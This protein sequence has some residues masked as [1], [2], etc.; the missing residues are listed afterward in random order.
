[1][2]ASPRAH[3]ADENAPTDL[4]R[5]IHI[6]FAETVG[7][8]MFETASASGMAAARCRVEEGIRDRTICLR[9]AMTVP[10]AKGPMESWQRDSMRTTAQRECCHLKPSAPGLRVPSSPICEL[11][12]AGG[13]I[14]PHDRT[15]CNFAGAGGRA[16]SQFMAS[17]LA[18]ASMH[19]RHDDLVA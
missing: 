13:R 17:V 1:M 11:T 5:K 10:P 18:C 3:G 6:R 16:P 2:K 4:Q 12:L 14:A 7:K 9:G 19:G 8:R 15:E